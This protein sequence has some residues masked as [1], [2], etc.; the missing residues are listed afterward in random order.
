MIKVYDGEVQKVLIKYKWCIMK[1]NHTLICDNCKHENPLFKSTCDNCSHYLRAAE[2]NLDL[3]KTIWSL[4]E[5]PTSTLRSIIFA[6]HKNYLVFLL[7][8]F[9][10]KINLI[11]I[12]LN[13][14]FLDNPFV[15]FSSS[16]LLFGS[17]FILVVT[18]ILIKLITTTFNIGKKRTRFKDNL[19]LTVYSFTPTVLAVIFL[20]PIEYAIFGI[21]WFDYN[22]SPI[23]IKETT[24]YIFLIIELLMIVWSLFLLGRSFLIQT[25]SN[26]KAVASLVFL[27]AIL[28]LSLN[29]IFSIYFSLL[30]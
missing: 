28:F 15:K 25:N 9:S 11:N 17:I 10:I 7:V 30:T 21:N 6:E 2:V 12:V 23:I 26:A 3:W 24:A 16:N 13:S 5:K 1:T 22:P 14:A 18:L 8:L 20:L 29:I 4:F 27:I 19:A